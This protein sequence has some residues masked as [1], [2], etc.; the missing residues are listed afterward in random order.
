MGPIHPNGPQALA[1]AIEL[2]V[3]SS[4]L[5]LGR[6]A[7]AQ[8]VKALYPLPLPSFLS[9]HL[10][11][12]YSKLDLPGPAS[13]VLSLDPCP[14]VVSFT[15]L[16]SGAAQNYHPLLALRIFPLLLRSSSR[17]N[18]FT[19]PSV[20]KA[21]ASI[22]CAVAG[23]QLHAFSLKSGLLSDVFV[24]SAALDMYHKT[25][26]SSHACLL[27]D[28]MPHKNIVSWNA[29]MTNALIA[30]RPDAAIAAFIRL[31]VSG[32]EPNEVS[33][34]AFLN[35]C[36]AAEYFRLGS[37]LHSFILRFGF[38]PNLSVGNALVDFYGK[39]SCVLA[40]RQVFDEMLLK[41]DVSWCSIIVAHA[42]NAEEEVAFNLYIEARREGFVPTDFMI[43]SVLTTCSILS[44]LDLGRSLHAVAVRSCIEGSIFVGSALVDMYGKCG[45]IEDAK[46]VFDDMPDRN[47]VTW[48][49][50]ISG[51]AAQGNAAMALS[52]FDEMTR[53]GEVMPNYVTLV[54]VMSACAREGR[55]KEGMELFETMEE[56][57]G[58]KPRMEHYACAVDLLGRAGKEEKAY[59]I[60]KKMAMKPSVSVWGAL[61]N[62]CRIHRKAELGRIAAEELFK[63]D[64]L[65]SGNHVLLSNIY[66]SA[67]R[68]EESIE[69]RKDMND[70]GIKKEPGCSWIAWKD[71]IHVFQAKDAIHEK[72]GD[73]RATLAD[74]RRRM[75]AAGYTPDTRF[76]LYELEEEEK[77][78]ELHQHSEK[79]AVAFGLICIPAGIPIRISKNLRV[80]GDC[81]QAMKFISGIEGREIILRDNVRFHRFK[82]YKCSCR[83][84]W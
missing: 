10:I 33:F 53:G 79:L 6:A 26:L 76:A 68:W 61:L 19:L 29:V 73:I 65:D 38:D 39:C 12:M 43:S 16:I 21:A 35:A 72:I 18:D 67:G 28:E 1:G 49:A 59:E 80:C 13:L 45:S 83:D 66:A 2:A 69:V 54:C 60:I 23:I 82:D 74:L 30:G 46:Q 40:A 50:M 20:L 15:A 52:V 75:I 57:F 84:Y 55:L 48:N 71:E 64:P 22:P 37:Q 24:I 27:F 81:H 41:N 8:I 56:R 51:Y 58:I 17:P 11:N 31:R 32:E 3:S 5:L 62:A 47:S 70:V 25:G 4:S 42:Q 34:C 63:I 44:G 9:N 77:E 78:S 7:H 36:A 14:S